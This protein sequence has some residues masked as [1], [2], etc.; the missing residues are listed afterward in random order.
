M[1]KK[2]FGMMS[3]WHRASQVLT[4]RFQDSTA[5]CKWVIG[6][7]TT[8]CSLCSGGGTAPRTQ[9]GRGSLQ[10]AKTKQNKTKMMD[11]IIKDQIKA[12]IVELSM[13]TEDKTSK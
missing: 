9:H 11:Q 3:T 2:C 10:M 13:E 1:R 4:E 5:P 6:D 12:N 7:G 8:Y